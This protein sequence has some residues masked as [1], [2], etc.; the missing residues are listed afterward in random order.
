MLSLVGSL[1]SAQ[2]KF[3]IYVAEFLLNDCESVDVATKNSQSGFDVKNFLIT[4]QEKNKKSS[5]CWARNFVMRLR[6]SG[7]GYVNRYG[8]QA[9]ARLMK[10]GCGLKFRKKCMY[11]D[12][13]CLTVRLFHNVWIKGNSDDQRNV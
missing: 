3:K 6:N 8:I 10:S 11:F 2:I 5:L 9:K 7:K 12:S 13:Y 1:M 4:K